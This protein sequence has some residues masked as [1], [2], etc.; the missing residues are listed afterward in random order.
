MTEER[1]DLTAYQLNAYVLERLGINEGILTQFHQTNSNSPSYEEQLK[2]LQYDMLYGKRYVYEGKN[3][4][5]VKDM[6]MGIYNQVITDIET[7][8]N[9]IY[10]YGE[11]FTPWSRICINDKL[12][13]TKFINNTTLCMEARDIS[14]KEIC[15]AQVTDSNSLLSKS[16]LW[17]YTA[18]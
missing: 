9:K 11:N 8:N 4:Y 2:L 7:T 6:K 12:M 5:P 14:D 18:D 10:V 3:P 17:K 13:V 15:V 1:H 16:D